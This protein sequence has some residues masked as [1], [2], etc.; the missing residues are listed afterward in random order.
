MAATTPWILFSG[1]SL[2]GKTLS[3]ESV[4]ETTFETIQVRTGSPSCSSRPVVL[5]FQ[6]LQEI[7]VVLDEPVKARFPSALSLPCQ[8]RGILGSGCGLAEVRDVLLQASL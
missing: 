3:L 7:G 4:W 6:H 2:R 1:R 8:E 5:A